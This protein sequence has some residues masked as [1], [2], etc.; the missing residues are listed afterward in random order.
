MPFLFRFFVLHTWHIKQ[1]FHSQPLQNEKGKKDDDDDDKKSFNSSQYT[2]SLV[3]EL[4]L[5]YDEDLKYN[6]KK[7][8]SP[9]CLSFDNTENSKNPSDNEDEP[10]EFILDINED[11]DYMFSN[12]PEKE[13]NF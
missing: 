13:A 11:A 5:E 3:E 4:E 2:D 12:I 6:I 9:R 8:N 10:N 1:W 7:I